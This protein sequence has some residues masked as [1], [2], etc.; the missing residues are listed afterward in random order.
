MQPTLELEDWVWD[1]LLANPPRTPSPMEEDLGD[2]EG[3][4]PM[5]HQTLAYHPHP[6]QI[7]YNWEPPITMIPDSQ[8]EDDDSEDNESVWI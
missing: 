1:F 6:N 8:P 2:G 3:L 7:D 5:Q 4:P